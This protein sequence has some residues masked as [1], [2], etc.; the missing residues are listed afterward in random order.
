VLIKDFANQA[1]GTCAGSGCPKS[2][3]VILS[4]GYDQAAGSAYSPG[5]QDGYWTLVNSP[6]AALPL[7]S[8]AWALN[9]NSSW[10]IL[11][12]SG[13]L[14][15]YQTPPL[16]INNPAPSNPYSFQRCFCTCDGIQSVGIDLDLL[17]DNAAEVYFDNVLI[18][19]QADTGPG[20]FTQPLHISTTISSVAEGMHCLRVDVRNLDGVYMGLDIQGKATSTAG[21][22]I[23]PPNSCCAR[24]GQIMGRK[25][26]DLTGEP[27][28]TPV[29]ITGG[30]GDHPGDGDHGKDGG[31]CDNATCTDNSVIL[32]TG[33]NQA[34][35]SLY[36]PEQP[37]GYWTL[38]GSPVGNLNI[39]SPAWVIDPYTYFGTLPGATLITAYQPSANITL[40]EDPNA[41]LD[42]FRFQRC[43]CICSGVQSIKIDMDML[44]DNT[45]DVYFDNILIGSQ[46]D[47]GLGSATTPLHISYVIDNVQPGKH[48]I[49]AEVRNTSGTVIGLDIAGTVTSVSG[50]PVS[51]PDY[52]CVTSGQVLGKKVDDLDGNG[53][54]D[55]G[56]PTL[57]GWTVT[58]VNNGTGATYTAVTDA[59]GYYYLSGLP[60][61]TYTV[62]E[63][64]QAGWTQ[65][66][67]AGGGAY[68]VTVEANGVV[69]GIDF[70][71]HEG[72]ST[73]GC[74]CT[75]PGPVQDNVT[76]NWTFLGL[77][78]EKQLASGNW[79]FPWDL[80]STITVK[81]KRSCSPGGPDCLLTENWT[82]ERILDG[83]GCT[84]TSTDQYWEGSGPVA[85]FTPACWG[86]FKVTLYAYCNGVACPPRI[87][88]LQFSPHFGPCQC[89]DDW[90]PG[91]VTWT[92]PGYTGC[93]AAKCAW[94][95]VWIPSWSP[96]M[97]VTENSTI[98]CS[99]DCPISLPIYNYGVWDNS[100]GSGIPFVRHDAPPAV[101]FEPPHPGIYIVCQYASCGTTPCEACC[102]TIHIGSVA[103]CYCLGW[104]TAMVKWTDSL[105]DPT[106][107]SVIENIQSNIISI[108]HID[109]NSYVDVTKGVAC[110]PGCGDASENWTVLAPDGGKLAEGLGM[111]AH[112]M[113]AASNGEYQVIFQAECPGGLSC[114][115]KTVLVN[116]PASTQ[117]S[118]IWDNTTVNW[119]DGQGSS[120][121]F[122]NLKCG[123]NIFIE[124]LDSCTDITITTVEHC[125]PDCSPPAGCAPPYT[126]KVTDASGGSGPWSGGG[127]TAR[128]KPQ[129][130]GKYVVTFTTQCNTVPC[131]CSISIN[132][133]TL[134]S[135]CHAKGAPVTVSWAPDSLPGTIGGTV[136]LSIGG[137]SGPIQVTPSFSQGW[138]SQ[139]APSYNWKVMLGQDVVGSGSGPNV[140]FQPQ[141][142]DASGWPYGKHLDYVVTWDVTCGTCTVPAACSLQIIITNFI[143]M[144]PQDA[145]PC[146]PWNPA[147]VTWT[148][149]SPGTWT[150]ACGGS[151]ATIPAFTPGMAVSIRPGL[152]CTDTS[153]APSLIWVVKTSSGSVVQSGKGMTASFTPRGAGSYSADFTAD[154][155]GEACPSSC[156]IPVRIGAS[157]ETWCC[158]YGTV[159]STTLSQCTQSNGKP[160]T[161]Q[162]EAINNCKSTTSSELV[163]C[164]INWSPQQVTME[165][166]ARYNGR[167]FPN[168]AAAMQG[169]ARPPTETLVWCCA[170]GRVM[171]VPATQCMQ[172]HG[173][174]YTCQEEA[175]RGCHAPLG[176]VP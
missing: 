127:L 58:A 80:G 134:Q 109:N 42:P 40:D 164:C 70:G 51:M 126:W 69:T 103:P 129:Q 119:F 146:Q 30:D 45:A 111:T 67:P 140:S 13:W 149:S 174:Q 160:Y 87:I 100:T 17:V 50:G 89:I 165:Q 31:P 63:V 54:I 128:F 105:Q 175:S 57:P 55:S 166:C 157:S 44:V 151:G 68:T 141:V 78:R 74:A 35:G 82:I 101:S 10:S 144:A 65:T 20:S 61:G 62:S 53:I 11:P 98:T 86:F 60:A 172:F 29:I 47:Q 142:D 107:Q 123:D 48:C 114:G 77:P 147:T 167:P 124:F 170:N 19:S 121:Q 145:G 37:D 173:T 28:D 137:G 131:S 32:N 8:P 135:T 64:P 66:I 112:F 113:P 102:T 110:S 46:T 97:T 106:N 2:T 3:S 1:T 79:S 7:P 34:T 176:P 41:T 14:S 148:G 161:T 38:V 39:P 154:C 169:C 143:F 159:Y 85:S 171:Q 125:S 4:T 81:T 49:Y 116:I 83:E 156:T 168:E 96:G 122:T 91:F 95:D 21:A 56:E 12:Y 93:V 117:C 162:A 139:G 99:E 84:S 118:C 158:R 6:D 132:I 52:C 115:Q 23:F 27:P 76:V 43:F 130:P 22:A 92:T 25:V 136:N 75:D 59:S 24:A 16:L 153:Q 15:A 72:I 133:S 5:Q 88:T 163:W 108:P 26:N 104:S 152:S 155:G 33:Y 90:T 18:G 94:G 71:N 120:R 73:V 9:K 36:I 150:G 138:C